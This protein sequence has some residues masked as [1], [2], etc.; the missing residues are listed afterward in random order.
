MFRYAASAHRSK[1]E[2][3]I[4]SAAGP[5]AIYDANAGTYAAGQRGGIA[6]FYTGNYAYRERGAAYN[7][8]TGAAA[9]LATPALTDTLAVGS[10]VLTDG[11]S[12]GKVY[13]LIGKPDRIVEQQNRFG[14]VAGERF[15]Y[16][17]NGKTVP[18]EVRDG[19]CSRSRKTSDPRRHL[20]R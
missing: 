9:A 20:I 10:S 17:R 3:K 2:P 4:I 12:V 5:T 6:D 18:I 16:Y 19:R 7:E 8:H 15:E 1:G 11:D 13:R 14:A